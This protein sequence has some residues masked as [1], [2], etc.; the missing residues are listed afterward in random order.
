MPLPATEASFARP[1]FPAHRNNLVLLFFTNILAW[2][3]AFQY[4][5]IWRLGT[6]HRQRTY[7]LAFL[8]RF[9][10]AWLSHYFEGRS[11]GYDDLLRWNVILLR[12][13][14]MIVEREAITLRSVV[15]VRV[16]RLQLAHRFWL[17]RVVL[18]LMAHALLT[19]LLRP[20]NVRTRSL[21]IGWVRRDN[22]SHSA[23]IKHR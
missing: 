6:G 11:D 23:G 1:A 18:G 3:K 22:A 8:Q 5:A 2:A 21:R 7:R 13:T 19:S 14:P 9:E 17:P 20:R 12:D 10:I 15:D 4:A 16:W